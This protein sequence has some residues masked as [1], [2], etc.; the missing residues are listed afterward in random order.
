[1]WR[2][3]Y[4]DHHISKLGLQVSCNLIQNAN[5]VETVTHQKVQQTQMNMF[6]S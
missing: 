2:L 1:M 4:N 3:A 5:T 6:Q